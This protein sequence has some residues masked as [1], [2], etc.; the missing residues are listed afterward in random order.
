MHLT[1]LP[2]AIPGVKLIAT[3]RFIA[4]SSFLLLVP[5]Y[6]RLWRS[7][8]RLAEFSVRSSASIVAKLSMHHSAVVH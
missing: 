4:K 5:V 6:D 1:F 2:A 7:D 3:L 8:T